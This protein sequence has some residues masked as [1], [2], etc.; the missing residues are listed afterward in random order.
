MTGG[1]SGQ[2]SSSNVQPSA[3]SKKPPDPPPG[4]D[5]SASSSKT[6]AWNQ[7]AATPKPTD[8]SGF[9]TKNLS[10][11]SMRQEAL[12]AKQE[13][14]KEAAIKSTVLM[15]SVN[16]PIDELS[17]FVLDQRK[18]AAYA[19]FTAYNINDKTGFLR[20]Q[21]FFKIVLT[22]CNR[23][24]KKI[25]D[26]EYEKEVE[27]LKSFTF[28]KGKDDKSFK[29][30]TLKAISEDEQIGRGWTLNEAGVPVK[31][32]IKWLSGSLIPEE[33][34]TTHFDELREAIEEFVELKKIQV[35]EEMVPDM[36]IPSSRK[37]TFENSIMFRVEKFKKAVPSQIQLC[38]FVRDPDSKILTKLDSGAAKI[39]I[40][41]KAIGMDE[42]EM[43]SYKKAVERSK[44]ICFFCKK[45]GHLVNE[46][47]ELKK[48][49]ERKARNKIVEFDGV[50]VDKKSSKNS[51]NSKKK[52]SSGKNGKKAKKSANKNDQHSH[53]EKTSVA[54]SKNNEKDSSTYHSTNSKSVDESD[55]LEGTQ[56]LDIQLV[57]QTADNRPITTSNRFDAF[58]KA[59][60]PPVPSKPELSV[61][62]KR[63]T[64]EIP[65]VNGFMRKEGVGPIPSEE[66]AGKEWIAARLANW[67]GDAMQKKKDVKV[68]SQIQLYDHVMKSVKKQNNDPAWKAELRQKLE[69]NVH[70]IDDAVTGRI[71][72]RLKS[73]D[74]NVCVQSAKPFYKIFDKVDPVLALFDLDKIFKI[75]CSENRTRAAKQNNNKNNDFLTMTICELSQDWRKGV[76]QVTIEEAMEESV[77]V[78]DSEDNMGGSSVEEMS[79]REPA[80]KKSSV[81]G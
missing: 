56:D 40:K 27:A 78:I 2:P 36:D 4:G 51:G 70:E 34:W 42:K 53:A 31:R 3:S 35:D 76:E 21:C 38:G 60:N 67:L 5:G 48:N 22:N 65:K 68:C 55:T 32:F 16:N 47:D 66:K 9:K 49:K 69:S 73:G 59:P 30:L 39:T 18:H 61:S 71:N 28:G 79:P 63:K 24:T 15:Y 26:N 11:W 25:D 17:K 64:M 80:E 77:T 20:S 19:G 46:C 54:T 58:R 29:R 57:G 62:R 44:P 37:G 23:E 52:S 33:Y 72:R 75:K 10:A 81:V 13:L 74:E 50:R 7:T 6:K 8:Q 41:L 14:H 45:E 1:G 12:K 43:D